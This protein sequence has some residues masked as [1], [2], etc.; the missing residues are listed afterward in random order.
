MT[1][2]GGVGQPIWKEKYEHI[3]QIGIPRNPQRVLKCRQK[4]IGNHGIR[5]MKSS[6]QVRF[7]EEVVVM[8][9]L[10]NTDLSQRFWVH[11]GG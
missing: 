6:F 5:Q 1:R 8:E 7:S 10:E 3:R 9:P 11:I 4:I 2:V